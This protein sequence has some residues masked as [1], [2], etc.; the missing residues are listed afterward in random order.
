MKDCA[1]KIDKGKALPSNSEVHSSAQ[2]LMIGLH[3]VHTS[4]RIFRVQGDAVTSNTN[5][6][7]FKDHCGT[8]P[9][10]IALTWTESQTTELERARIRVSKV[11]SF[12]EA[13]NFLCRHKRECE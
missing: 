2:M 4:K 10:V 9:A 1:A 3:L 13:L 11:V 8:N 12:L 6:Q 7:R 5:V